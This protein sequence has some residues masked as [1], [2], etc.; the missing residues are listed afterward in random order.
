MS[1]NLIPQR[2]TYSLTKGAQESS[3]D[4]PLPALFAGCGNLLD[5][6]IDTR[7][8]MIRQKG[9][10]TMLIE[11]LAALANC[12]AHHLDD[13]LEELL[14][15]VC[16]CFE[17]RT[18]PASREGLV[19]QL[20]LVT[21]TLARAVAPKVRDMETKFEMERK[22]AEEA[23]T[24][25][26][27]EI[28]RL[29]DRLQA[30]AEY[31]KAEIKVKHSHGEIIGNSQGL[32]RVLHQVEQ[33]ALADCTVLI[34]GETGTGKELIAQQ[35][36]RLS[37]RKDRLMVL[38]NCAALPSALV[39]S[40]LFGRERG[41][42]TGALT[43]QV[44][45]FEVADGSTVF[46]DEVGELP[47]EVQA[48]L[49]RVLQQ[50]EFQ[51]LGSPRTHKVNVR[52]IAATNR[53]LAEEVR[54][55][56]FREDVYYRLNVFPIH[57]PPL[58]ERVE[59]I[60][61]MVFAF[62]EEFSTRMGKKLTNVPRKAMETLQKHSWPGNIRELRNVIEHSVILSSGDTLKLSV[63]GES[64]T[65]EP[66]AMTLEDVEREHILKT[67]EMTEWRIKGAH[68]AATRLAMQP[69]TLYSR[70]QRLGIPHRRQ[71]DEMAA[72]R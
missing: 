20:K 47:M 2:Q 28:E 9:F 64:P 55:G 51:R 36:H 61:A 22:Q 11:G 18:G 41:A 23:L 27:A 49:L 17:S 25:S 10:N 35:I 66:Q 38:V 60:P 52:V 57:I 63:F 5:M 58:R 69:S 29:K 53:D 68:G 3:G 59:D 54:K 8:H 6:D 34:N 56:K 24:K 48:K 71:K 33:V 62:M 15:H 16:E 70:M 44:G 31:L 43:S 1:S 65:R 14:R 39:E 42:Y 67:L 50:G 19:M 45:R 4:D 37:G 7:A 12:P 46:L 40:E 13:K 32:K 72:A 21:Q 30:E 26:Y